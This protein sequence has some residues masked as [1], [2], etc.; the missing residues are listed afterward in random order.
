MIYDALA[1]IQKNLNDYLNDYLE[2]NEDKV[3]LGNI[4][5]AEELGGSNNKLNNHVV[6]SL[7]N[8]QEEATLKNAP[9]YRL[10]NG[11]TVYQNPPVHLNLFI[12]FSVLYENYDKSLKLLSWVIEFLQGTKEF[13]FLATPPP[14]SIGSI[15]QDVRI[16]MDL[17]PLTFEQV[18]HL[19]GSLGGKQVPFVL[20]RA[21][22]V[23][24]EAPKRKAE[25]EV[26]TEVYINENGGRRR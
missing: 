7:V 26:I 14:D 15:S 22:L 1:L 9:N 8:S 21:R 12:L 5:M 2:E 20:Y 6:M 13:S 11:R 17:Y 10:E 24:L 25:G 18:N 16:V 4:S 19:W 3:I 23:A